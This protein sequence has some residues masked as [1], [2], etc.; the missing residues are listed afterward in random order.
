[1]EPNTYS[2]ELGNIKPSNILGG[3]CREYLFVL[4]SLYYG[5]SIDNTSLF[6]LSETSDFQ[7]LEIDVKAWYFVGIIVGNV[8]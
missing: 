7:L 8:K 6:I 2:K 4:P 5:V 1:M 3:C